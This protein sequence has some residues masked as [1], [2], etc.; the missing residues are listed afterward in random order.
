[1]SMFSF[2]GGSDQYEG[3]LIS[4][5]DTDFRV[6]LEKKNGDQF[7]SEKK[8]FPKKFLS[9]GQLE[10]IAK[11]VGKKIKFNVPLVTKKK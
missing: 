7:K 2:A 1:M 5:N 6:E 10:N 11:L 4:Y 8:Y 9:E 3:K